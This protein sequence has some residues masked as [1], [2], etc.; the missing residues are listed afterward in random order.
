MDRIFF[1]QFWRDDFAV[2]SLLQH[3]EGL[4]AAFTQHQQFAV[5]G[6]LADAGRDEIRKTPGDVF[7]GARIKPRLDMAAFVA[8]GHRLHADAVPFPFRD[9]VGGIEIGESASSIACASMTGRNGVGSR[10]TGFS[11]G[12]PARRTDRDRAG[13]IPGHISSMSW[14]SL[15]PRWR[16]RFW[17]AAPKSRSASR[18]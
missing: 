10:L 9:E 18:R 16:R 12:L 8:A 11:R 3:V 2:E 13:S 6:D 1:D 17:P 4:H 15:S 14:A 5:D 7:P